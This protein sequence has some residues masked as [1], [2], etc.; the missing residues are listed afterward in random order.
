M[1]LTE[2]PEHT[3]IDIFKFEIRDSF[4]CTIFIP[5]TVRF[6]DGHFHSCKYDFQGQYTFE[7]W[8]I[9]GQIEEFIKAKQIEFNALS[10]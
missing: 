7:Q 6:E 9:L 10:A 1:K 3:R 8:Q 5:V 2:N 4:P